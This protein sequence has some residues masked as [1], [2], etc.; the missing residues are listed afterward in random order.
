MVAYCT[1]RTTL[2]WI[3]TSSVKKLEVVCFGSDC[4]AHD[5]GWRHS[6]QTYSDFAAKPH[7][8]RLGLCTMGSCRMGLM[9]ALTDIGPLYFT[10]NNLS[11]GICMNF[12][13]MFVMMVILD[14]FNPEHV[15]DAF[16]MSATLMWTV[17]DHPAY[18]MMSGWSIV[19]A[20]GSSF[21]DDPRAFYLQHG[22]KRCYI[23]YYRQFL[24][25]N[26]PHRRNKKAFSTNR[27]ERKVAHMRLTREHVHDW[28]AEFSPT[29]EVPL[30]L[31]TDY[32]S[33]HKWMKKNIF[34]KLEYLGMHMIR[35]NLDIMHIEKN[36]FD[37]IFDTVMNIK[38]KTKDNWNV[39][40]NLKIIC[41]QPKLKVDERRQNISPKPYIVMKLPERSPPLTNPSFRPLPQRIHR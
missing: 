28:I 1:E 33:G 12:E 6:N 10:R 32:C 15:I 24:P 13:Y 36:V 37:N 29:F 7:K 18:G 40:K 11:L 39:E 21:L 2:I 5:V 4:R 34:W 19:G 26:H 27:V 14:L 25:W 16:M 31:P 38:G 8:V 17:N 35:H 20:M 30:S 9:V 41:N 3:T 23:D 22:R